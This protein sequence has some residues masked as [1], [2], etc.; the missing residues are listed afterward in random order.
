[1]TRGG[2]PGTFHE[3]D[4]AQD[5]WKR[6][7]LDAREQARE[8]LSECATPAIDNENAVNAPEL[9]QYL[10]SQTLDYYRHIA[11]KAATLQS[12]VWERELTTVRV[13]E[14]QTI[15]G[16]TTNWHGDYD[17]DDVLGQASWTHKPV[18]LETLR[19]EWQRDTRVIV[20][21]EIV[22]RATGD[23]ILEHREFTLHLPPA[24]CEE[25]IGALDECL[26][27]LRWLPE[28]GEI[29]IGADDVEVPD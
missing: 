28:A 26:D 4:P 19:Q 7:M 18:Q 3:P 29:S 13:P 8:A 16:G 2:Q 5:A 6:S 15:D 12:D 22:H 20:G 25:V 14:T 23:E 27:D 10:H 9:V 11:P 24:A 21:I 17:V 1:M